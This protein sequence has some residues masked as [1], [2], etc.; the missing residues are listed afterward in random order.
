MPP[1]LA[2]S[3]TLPPRSPPAQ[4]RPPSWVVHRPG[5]NAQPS[6]WLPKRTRLTAVGSV[7]SV[8]VAV[9]A[10]AGAPTACQDRP[11]SAVAATDGQP[12]RSLATGDVVVVVDERREVVVVDRRDVVVG[13]E[14]EVDADWGQGNEPS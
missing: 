11:P 10:V 2:R 14:V 7:E 13:G 3:V 9:S 5:P 8:G 4:V 1:A 6:R 12:M